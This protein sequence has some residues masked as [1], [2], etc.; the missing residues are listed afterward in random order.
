[1]HERSELRKM[2]YASMEMH[3]D[4]LEEKLEADYW[5][6]RQAYLQYI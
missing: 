5:L 4:I 1:M 6:G 2:S 3:K